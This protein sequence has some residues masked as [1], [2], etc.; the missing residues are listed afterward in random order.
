MTIVATQTA[1]PGRWCGA[2]GKIDAWQRPSASFVSGHAALDRIYRIEAFPPHPT[3]VRA[4]EHIEAGGGMAANAAVAIARLGGKAELW[5]RIG[6]DNAGNTIRAGLKAEHVDVRYVQSFEGARSS[7]SAIIVDDRGERLIVGQRDAGMPSDTSWLPLE[8]VKDADA[9]LGDLRWLEGV[10]AVFAHARKDGVP[11]I[12]DADLGAREALVGLLKL[13]DYAIFSGARA[14]RVRFRRHGRGAARAY[15]L[16]HRPQARRGDAR[17]RR[18]HLAR[19]RRQRPRP[20]VQRERDRHDRRR[21]RLPRHIRADAGGR[22]HGTRDSARF[23]AAAAAL[24]CTRL[25]SR[26]GLPSRAELRGILLALSNAAPLI[27][28]QGSRLPRPYPDLS[29][30]ISVVR[31]L[32]SGD[33]DLKG[34]ASVFARRRKISAMGGVKQRRTQYG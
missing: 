9:V 2:E 13:T 18:L 31:A 23:A 34:R 33:C 24:K 3:K 26:A 27:A 16:S 10:R 5:S 8:R 12:L 22:T 11:T 20:G 19:S 7:T 4:L 17:Q 1:T 32:R 25:G 15:V 14:A 21:R 28:R 6:D 29:T 30:A